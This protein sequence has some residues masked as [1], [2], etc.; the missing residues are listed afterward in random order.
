M[1]DVLSDKNKFTI[2][3]WKNDTLLDFAIKQEKHINKVLKKIV[4][5]N[6]TI[7][8]IRKSLKT[9]GSRPGVIYSSCK[10]DKAIVENCPPFWPTLLALN[11]PTYILLEFLV[12]I[13]KPLTTNEFTI[14]DSFH[15]AEEIVDQ[16][17]HSLDELL[18]LATKDSHFIF[19]HFIK[20]SMMWP[21]VPP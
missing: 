11:I 18:F 20:K 9:V 8:K 6:S 15:F 12:P 7:Q 4:E 16:Q 17:P 14:K 21:W 13:L 19:E 10:L 2:V 5:S 1:N 3:N